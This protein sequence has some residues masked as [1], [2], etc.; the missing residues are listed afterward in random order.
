MAIA[1]E[2]ETKSY[3]NNACKNARI[4]Y[5]F[6]EILVKSPKAIVGLLPRSVKQ[7]LPKIGLITL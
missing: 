3:F 6:E 2:C 1:E 7:N 4:S 5:I